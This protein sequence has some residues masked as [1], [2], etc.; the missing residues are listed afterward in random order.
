MSPK[1]VS[2]RDVARRAEVHFTTVSL[3]LRNSPSLPEATRLRIQN[4]AKEMGYRP[5]PMLSALQV[6]RKNAKSPRFEGTFAWFNNYKDPSQLYKSKFTKVYFESARERCE[7]LG[8]RL[9]E[10]NVAN[11][12]RARLSGIFRARNIQGLLLPPQPYNRTHLNFDWENYSAVTFGYS[13][14]RPRLHAVANAQYSASR[15]AV[16]VLRKYGHRRIG[17]V[18][19][20]NI[21]ERTDQNFSSGFLVEQ[22]R[23]HPSEQIPMLVLTDSDDHPTQRR[24]LSQWYN[25][26]QPT[27]ISTLYVTIPLYMETLKIPYSKCG[28]ALLG[29]FESDR[30][31]FAGIDQNERVIGRTAVDFLVGM[32][33]RNERGIPETPLRILVDGRWVDG[34]TVHRLNSERTSKKLLRK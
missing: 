10:F 5:D 9:E 29:L 28:L 19:T 33:H 16:R 11:T 30:T 32:I 12:S 27:V 4:L 17:F 26:Y 6:Y 23:F 22:R 3:A 25:E 34:S 15:L 31:K 20:H 1:R 24:M 13:L 2:Q 14:S 7:E 18:T 8:Y 21:D